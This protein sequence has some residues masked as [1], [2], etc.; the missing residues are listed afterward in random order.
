[1]PI[2]VTLGPNDN[3]LRTIA[4]AP[5]GSTIR[6]NAGTYQLTNGLRL[7]R[8]ISIEG[9]GATPSKL[10]SSAATAVISYEG[11]GSLSLKNLE[12]EHSGNQAADILLV[13]AGRID[14]ERLS[15]K[16]AKQ[17]DGQGGRCWARV[18][19]SGYLAV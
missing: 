15:L 18:Q 11:R 13:K 5:A 12:I 16:G 17:I 2:D 6:L 9:I 8:A 7:T 19:G 3:I 4:S 1:M 14:G 10:V